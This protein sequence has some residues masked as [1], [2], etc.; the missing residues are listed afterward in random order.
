MRIRTRLAPV[1]LGTTVL[2][3]QTPTAV[4]QS[5]PQSVVSRTDSAVD[6]YT[7]FVEGKRLDLPVD[8]AFVVAALDRLVSAVEALAFRQATPSDKILST[9]HKVRREIRRLE[10]ISGDSPSQIRERW[11]VFLAVAQLVADVSREIGPPGAR[12]GVTSS[13]LRAADGLDY[14]YPLRWQ[15]NNIE[16]YFDLAS[17]ALKQMVPDVR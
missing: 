7:T 12:Q 6:A 11:N 16:I 4:L 17:R 15:P 14:D 13:L 5:R 3:I 9:A 10:P 2:V 8:R 1:V